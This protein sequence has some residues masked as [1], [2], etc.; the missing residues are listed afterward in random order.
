MYLPFSSRPTRTAATVFSNGMSLKRERGAG[1]ADAEHVGVELGIDRKHGRDDLNVVAETFGKERTNRPIDLTRAE[2]RVFGRTPFTLDVTA[3]NL[4]GGIHLLFEIAGKGEEVD[5]FARL[6]G[7]GHGAE[8]DVLI[9]ITNQR[10]AVCLL[11]E[12]AGF[13]GHRA[14]ADRQGYGFGHVNS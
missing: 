7:G 9:A 5:A 1:G 6:L 10:G 2:H 8:H 14:P 4:S 11:R 12:F 13:D 3:G